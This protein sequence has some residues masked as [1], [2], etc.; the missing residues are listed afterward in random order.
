[1]INDILQMYDPAPPVFDNISSLATKLGWT[2]VAAHTALE[3]LHKNGIDDRWS[4]EF[5]DSITRINYGQVRRTHLTS[6]MSRLL[7]SQ[8]ID[9]IHALEALVSLASNGASSVKGGNYQIYE[10]FLNDSKATVLL[11][12]EVRHFTQVSATDVPHYPCIHCTQVTSIFRSSPSEPW[13]LQTSG[14]TTPRPYRAI[15]LAAPLHQTGIQIHSSPSPASV[16]KQPYVHLHVTLLTTTS[17]SFNATYFNLPPHAS[18]PAM[19]LTSNN[20]ARQGGPAPHFNSLS[21]IRAVRTRSLGEWRNARGEREWVVKVFSKE[22]ISDTWLAEMFDGRV[23][24]A[25]RKE[26]DAYPVLPP[27]TDFPPVKLAEGLYYVNAF[28]PCG[29]SPYSFSSVCAE[30]GPCY[31]L[32]STMETETV[33]ARNVVDLLLREHFGAGLCKPQVND[34]GETIREEKGDGFVYGWDC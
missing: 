12:S 10:R 23:G 28:E 9:R 33:A 2:D 24:W 27:A 20:G 4:L 31:R 22:R 5:V 19:V 30:R 18:V 17:P 6:A 13:L 16:P 3:Y 7:L 26:W 15:I 11:N 21:Y 1:M 32:I 29:D 8:D 25:L 34:A 14:S